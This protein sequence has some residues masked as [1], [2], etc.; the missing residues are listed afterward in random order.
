MKK[1]IVAGVFA[2]AT[3]V[4]LAMTGSAARIN[5][6]YDGPFTFHSTLS[7]PSPNYTTYYTSS[8]TPNNWGGYYKH[9]GTI[10]TSSGNKTISGYSSFYSNSSTGITKA[11]NNMSWYAVGQE[12]YKGTTTVTW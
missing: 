2:L 8:I 3:I 10:S 12:G 4:A 6:A 1:R 9:S 11:T 5:T 7:A